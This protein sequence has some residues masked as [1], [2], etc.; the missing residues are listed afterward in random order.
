MR[1][2]G[3]FIIEFINNNVRSIP[4]Y[5]ANQAQNDINV[6]FTKALTDSIFSLI[7]RYLNPSNRLSS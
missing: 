3:I 4:S 1:F 6:A 2:L 5:D 7:D